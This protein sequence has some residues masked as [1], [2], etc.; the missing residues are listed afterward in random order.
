MI[1]FIT[2]VV[3]VETV[4]T[5]VAIVTVVAVAAVTI[6]LFAANTMPAKRIVSV[7]SVTDVAFS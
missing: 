6:I 3:A 5:V 1:R 2:A 7:A 4:I